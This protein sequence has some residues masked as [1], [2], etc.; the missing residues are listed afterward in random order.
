MKTIDTKPKAEQ[1]TA[2]M[3]TSKEALAHLN[4]ERW[5]STPNRSI[6]SQTRE[7]GRHKR[8]W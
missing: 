6:K 8:T 5:L 7:L 1:S 2:Q 4:S 3:K